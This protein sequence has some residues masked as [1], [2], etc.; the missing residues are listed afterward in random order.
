[1]PPLTNMWPV[2][3]IDL[4]M[5]SMVAGANK[6]LLDLAGPGCG[7]TVDLKDMNDLAIVSGKAGVN[8]PSKC[9]ITLRTD[10]GGRIQFLIDV[11]KFS[12]CSAEIYIS[13]TAPLTSI[14][15]SNNNKAPL[16]KKSNSNFLKIE[17]RSKD[18]RPQLFDISIKLM[19]DLGPSLLDSKNI[20]NTLEER[21][22][23]VDL[24]GA[25]CDASEGFYLKD[26]NDLADVF[27]YIHTS[28]MATRDHCDVT[29]RADA[30][31]VLQYKIEQIQFY[32]CGIDIIIYDNPT[33]DVDPLH[34]I[35]CQDNAKVICGKSRTNYIRIRVRKATPQ[36]K[37]Y[38]FRMKL[39]SD[40]GAPFYCDE[41][42]KNGSAAQVSVYT[43]VIAGIISYL[44]MAD[45]HLT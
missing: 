21:V 18:T 23:L 32:E 8:A 45:T 39:R 16:Y 1:M 22:A 12:G 33:Q 11:I 6:V 26:L 25:G 27:A 37:N 14:Q 30:G 44:T 31:H 3:F 10:P 29:L 7:Q 40:L 4:W 41:P 42:S 15:C 38:Q 9:E 34:V 43:V 5:I 24:N 28:A 20:A 2:L 17:V 36:T 13:D 35:K 19:N